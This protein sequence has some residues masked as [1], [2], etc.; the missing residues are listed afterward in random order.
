MHMTGYRCMS[1]GNAWGD[2]LQEYACPSCGGNLDVTYDYELIRSLLELEP[3]FASGR[4]DIFRYLPFLPVADTDSAP[5][6]KVGGT[7]LYHAVRLGKEAGL[8]MVYLK[9][10][11]GNPSSSFKD[12]ASAIVLARARDTGA[13]VIACA[14]TGN[15]GSSMACLAAGVG[16]PCVIFV[17]EKAPPAKIAQLLIYGARVLAVRGSYDDARDLCLKVCGEKGW[18]NR[19]TGFNPFTR[20]GKKTCSYEIC[21]QLEW[22]P[23]DRVVVA[24]GDGNIISG[25]WKGMKDLHAAGLIDRL[26]RIDAAQAVGSSAISKTVHRLRDNGYVPAGDDWTGVSV[27]RVEADTLADSISVDMPGDGL[28]AV[29]AVIE[30][31]GS[32]VTVSDEA[33][34]DAVREL[35]GLTGVFAE[36]SAAASWACLKQ[37]SSENIV[38]SDDRIV[39]LISGNGLKDFS[40]ARRVAGN[41]EVINP[42]PQDAFNAVAR[43]GL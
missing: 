3:L 38:K 9:D 16:L 6:L 1:C 30:S 4:T 18:F 34:L 27:E 7:P 15:A 21:E 33:I 20:E 11:T 10:D 14:S 26:P 37:M 13:R 39:C 32:A 43:L 12:R 5:L 42:C 23:P 2:D 17:P 41:P 31:E 8:N 28:A 36:P 35:A 19:N 29:R 24:A 40:S 22:N 25:I